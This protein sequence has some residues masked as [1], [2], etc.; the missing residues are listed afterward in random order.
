MHGCTDNTADVLV[1]IGVFLLVVSIS[2]LA[3][4]VWIKTQRQRGMH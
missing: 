2:A 1:A 4:H 3:I